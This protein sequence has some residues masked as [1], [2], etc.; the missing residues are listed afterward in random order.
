VIVDEAHNIDKTC[1]E[2]ASF[3]LAGYLMVECVEELRVATERAL[4][5]AGKAVDPTTGKAGNKVDLNAITEKA[6]DTPIMVQLPNQTAAE[7]TPN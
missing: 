1:S 3:D 6:A 7:V 2:A 5:L 4:G